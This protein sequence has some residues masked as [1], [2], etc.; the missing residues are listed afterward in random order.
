VKEQTIMKEIHETLWE[1]ENLYEE[2][3]I[4]SIE[5][6]KKGDVKVIAV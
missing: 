4:K 1:K 3:A 5:I 6:K 2:A